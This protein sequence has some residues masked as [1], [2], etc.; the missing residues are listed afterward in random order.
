M[1]N[2][3][4]NSKIFYLFLCLASMNFFEVGST[5]WL[6]VCVAFLFKMHFRIPKNLQVGCLVLFFLCIVVSTFSFG[7]SITY[8]IKALNY[9]LGFMVGMYGYQY[10]EDKI[11]FVKWSI[12]ALFFGLLIQLGLDYLYNL[13]QVFTYARRYYSIWTGEYIAVTLIGLL[14]SGII[15]YSF[16]GIFINKNKIIKL[17][18]ALGIVLTIAINLFTA[19]RT[20]IVLI[21]ICYLFMFLVWFE[22]S[23]TNNKLKKLITAVLLLLIAVALYHFNVMGIRTY[24]EG[25]ALFERMSESGIQS[26]RSDLFIT[27]LHGLFLYPLGGRRM[28]AVVGKLPHNFIQEAG[29]AFGIIAFIVLLAFFIM[30]LVDLF[31]VIRKRNKEDYHYLLISFCFTLFVQT[32]LEPIISGY[33]M[34]VWSL[35]FVYGMMKAMLNM[36]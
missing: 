5:L 30:F 20:P 8:I 21:A 17:L 33:P 2:N 28:S 35:I 12:F 14:S 19:T 36:E 15:G 26:S 29:D 22:G 11:K 3:I 1:S 23:N 13:N 27:F 25:S 31:K 4:E 34:I 24:I 7:W 9:P 32:C 6:L 18:S 10:S 16:Y